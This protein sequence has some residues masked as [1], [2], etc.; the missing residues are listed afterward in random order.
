MH[1]KTGNN[2]DLR[3]SQ[4]LKRVIDNSQRLYKGET[5]ITINKSQSRAEVEVNKSASIRKSKLS[6]TFIDKKSYAE[7]T[8]DSELKQR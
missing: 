5:T 8:Y 1:L 2:R 7:T 3:K 6:K 4:H